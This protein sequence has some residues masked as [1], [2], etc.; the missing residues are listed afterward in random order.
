[1]K[2]LKTS[3]ITRG[4]M[5]LKNCPVIFCFYQVLA[6]D[7]IPWE[8]LAGYPLLWFIF[9]LFAPDLIGSRMEELCCYIAKW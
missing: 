2:R 4:I 7:N 3:T 8:L 5:D 6:G 9:I 1:V